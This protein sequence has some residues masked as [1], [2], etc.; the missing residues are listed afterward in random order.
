MQKQFTVNIPDQLWINSWA[1]KKTQTWTYDGPKTLYVLVSRDHAV[2]TWSEEL[3]ER[4]ENASE[5]VYVLDAEKH[6]ASAF[7][8]TTHFQPIDNFYQYEYFDEINYDGSVHSAIANPR[9]QDIYDIEYFPGPVDHPQ[10]GVL[11]KPIYK[12]TETLCEQKAKERKRWVERYDNMYDFEPELQAT[13]DKFLLACNTYLDKMK[14]VYP[15]KFI[16][17]DEDEIPR[18]PSTLVAEFSKYP[19]IK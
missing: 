11:L 5:H 14:T 4:E 2:V 1:E 6:T 18:I 9:I 13:I 8:M 16:T 10:A 15:W 12:T 17:L 7:W 3:I 19:D